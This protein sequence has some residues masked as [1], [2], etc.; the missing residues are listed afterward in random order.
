MK[1]ATKTILAFLTAMTMTA[2]AMS[3]TPYVEGLY[4]A[5]EIRSLV[6]TSPKSLK[7]SRN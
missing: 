5:T 2:G 4:F 1:K 6:A 3:A 7:L